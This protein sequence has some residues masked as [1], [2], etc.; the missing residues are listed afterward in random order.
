MDSEPRSPLHGPFARSAGTLILLL[1]GVAAAGCG[2]GSAEGTGGGGPFGA[3][4]A[5]VAVVTVAPETLPI[6]LEY[7]AQ[8]LGSRE[9]EVR[10]RVTGI[11]EERNYREGGTVQAGQSLFTIDP[12]P[13]EV[14]VA[15]AEADLAA[16]VA[17]RE[18]ARREVARLKPLYATKAV[19]R[20]AYDDALS[21]AEIAAA[22]VQAA[23]ARLKEATLNL[24]YTRVESPISG[25]ASRALASEGSLVSGPNVLLTT[26]TQVDPMQVLFGIPD[27]VHTRLRQEAS[28]GQLQW[29]ADDRFQVTVKFSDGSTYARTGVLD[30]TDVRVSRETGTSE[31]RAEIPNPDGILR[32]GQFVRV[33]LNGVQRTGAF[34]VPQ[35]AVL[36]GPQ[37]KF[38]Y[39]VNGQSQAETRPVEVGEWLGESWIV[40][41]GLNAG[42]R[43]I[44]DGVLK[45]SPGALVQIAPAAA[46]PASAGSHS[47]NRP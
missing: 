4:P 11:L 22:D 38:V 46:A 12:A 6:V 15:R 8:T 24:A 41:G 17:R 32:P 34:R 27:S 21:A 9:V 5:P 33:A 40:T 39:V 30:F 26:V 25:I 3:G 31:A 13:F 14:A 28:A 29:P 42:D 45:L 19:S 37:G 10:A 1:I 20:K 47:V 43:V 35:R 18:Q 23:E 36:E 44:V 7:P 2:R 16:A